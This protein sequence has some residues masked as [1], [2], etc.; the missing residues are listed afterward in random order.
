[1]W[2]ANERFTVQEDSI[3]L[4][5][6]KLCPKHNDIAEVL[7]KVTVL[8]DFYN[9]SIFN[10]HAVAKRIVE[11]NPIDRIADGDTSL[12]NEVAAVSIGGKERKFYSFASKYCSQHNPDCF[13]IYDGLVVKMLSHFRSADGF[14]EFTREDLKDYT[15]FVRVIEAFKEFYGL[16]QFSLRWIDRYLWF[17]GRA[18]FG[19]SQPK[20]LPDTEP[21]ATESE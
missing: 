8:N 16:G 2:A 13:P 20:K 19:R 7:L 4:L 6:H 9:T 17:A 11:L 18:A 3:R 12:V 15:R 10:T 21:G 14:D 5:F 1:M